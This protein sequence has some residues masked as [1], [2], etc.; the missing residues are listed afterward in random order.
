MRIPNA[1]EAQQG[2][3][4]ALGG[5]A[6]H[7]YLL[8]SSH[9]RQAGGGREFVVGDRHNPVASTRAM[10][11]T[12][13]DFLTHITALVE[14]DTVELVHIGFM[15]KSVAID[16]VQAPSRHAKRNTVGL[17]GLCVDQG[18][19]NIAG[20]FASKVRWQHDAPAQL[21]EA[22]V[23]KAQAIFAVAGAIPDC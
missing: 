8:V 18:G 5:G 14:I 15:R 12:R 7:S 11:D 4:A 2:E 22:R 23:R 6:E 3:A 13:N 19:A 17:V 20:G 1:I 21:R 10:L 9:D 16:K